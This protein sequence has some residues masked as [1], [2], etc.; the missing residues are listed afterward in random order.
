MIEKL[1]PE[2]EALLP[3]YRDKWLKIGLSCEPL[4]PEKAKAAA[5][6]AYKKAGLEPPRIFVCCQSPFSGVIAATILKRASVGDSVGASVRD[7]VW[8]SVWAS[9]GAYTGSFFN[10]PR[11][12]W[13]YTENIKTNGYPFQPCVDLWERGLVPSFDGEVWR[14]HSGPNAKVIWEGETE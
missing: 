7:S 1:T 2:Q 3:V 10:L 9:V 14:L 5:I 8:D 13:K 12:A 6:L 4:D 11:E